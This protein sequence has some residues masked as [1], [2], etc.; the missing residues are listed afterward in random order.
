MMWRGISAFDELFDVLSGLRG[1]APRDGSSSTDRV[2]A[3]AVECLTRENDLVLRAELPGVD[4]A[5]VE[6]NVNGRQLTLSGE[7]KSSQESQE[8]NV[9]YRETVQGRFARTFT[10]PEGVKSEQIK[11]A[12]SNG[13]LEITM[14]AEGITRARTV[15]IEVGPAPRRTIQAA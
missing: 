10:L 8:R 6:V 12:F 13:V 2:W 11:A 14:P 15:P 7:K 9:H 3:P 5:Q 4:P 1:Q